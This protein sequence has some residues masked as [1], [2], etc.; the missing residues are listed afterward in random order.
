MQSQ[1]GMHYQIH[2][3]YDLLGYGVKMDDGPTPVTSRA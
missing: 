1:S 2:N 3:T